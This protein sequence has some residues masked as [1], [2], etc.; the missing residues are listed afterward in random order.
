MQAAQD[1][2][3]Q[4]HYTKVL[5]EYAKESAQQFA[6]RSRVVPLPIDAG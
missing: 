2:K 6:V 1:G 5:A 4:I 3:R